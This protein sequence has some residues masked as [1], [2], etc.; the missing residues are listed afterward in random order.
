ME[1]VSAFFDISKFADFQL[2]NG[3]VSRT[4]EVRCV[5]HLFLKLYLG[6]V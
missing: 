5:V 1:F 6:K 3:D 4:Q 2:E